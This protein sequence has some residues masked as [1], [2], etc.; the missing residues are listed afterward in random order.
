MIKQSLTRK[1]IRESILRSLGGIVGT[2]STT[3]DTSSLLD[4]FGL[5][6]LSDD[7][8]NGMMVY[9][10]K[11]AGVAATDKVWVSDFAGSTSDA[12]VSPV[13]SGT[14]TAGDTY[15]LY[16]R[17]LTVDDVHDVID[18]A[19]ISATRKTL[20]NKQTTDTF[21]F[22]NK[23]EYACL[24]GFVGVHTVEYVSS[25][26]VN[27]LLSDCET[28]WT[29]GGSVVATADSAFKRMGNYS[30][31]LVV[32]AGAAAGAVLGYI[33]ITSI[34]ISDCDKIEFDMYS[35]IALTAGYLDF[36]LDDTSGCISPLESIDIPAMT[37]GT[38]YR[39][40]LSLANPHSDTAI[41]SLGVVNTTDV[42]ACTLYFDNIHAV[43]DGSKIFK[44]LNPQLW[45][46]VKGSTNYLKLTYFPG[47]EVQLRISGYELP[48]IMTTDTETCDIDPEYVI[49]WSISELCLNHAKSSQL[50]VEGKK[51][52]GERSLALAERIKAGMSLNFSSDTRFL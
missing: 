34:D 14:I 19:I 32:G 33:D 26:G 2:V 48:T 8:I 12:T 4:T 1:E 31:K 36:V 9:L 15:E 25:I 43:K 46:L 21:T 42:G 22:T 10:T 13:A 24:T 41:I 37:A 20:V 28:A 50:D 49:R 17:P 7:E 3:G 40:S 30:A 29:A 51:A 16:P 47:D 11:I 6:G 45:S 39:H 44:E 52:L 35:S 18:R 38:W 23:Y 5:Y 27:Y